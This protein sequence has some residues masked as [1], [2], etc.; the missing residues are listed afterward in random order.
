MKR[1]STDTNNAGISTNITKNIARSS[2]DSKTFSY[3]REHGKKPVTSDT[4]PRRG[5]RAAPQS[6]RLAAPDVQS[7]MGHLAT[8][9]RRASSATGSSPHTLRDKAPGTNGH[10]SM[11]EPQY[12]A[13]NHGDMVPNVFQLPQTT[14][15]GD[16]GTTASGVNHDPKITKGV[17]NKLLREQSLQQKK[18]SCLGES[19]TERRDSA[20]GN[21]VLLS[22]Y[23]GVPRSLRAVFKSGSDS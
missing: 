8:H 2:I 1:P 15:T 23:S 3:K 20:T 13:R 18:S 9:G 22:Y 6:K 12:A 16:A 14:S 4:G 5:N 10:D 19:L 21:D 7:Y 17:W 11:F